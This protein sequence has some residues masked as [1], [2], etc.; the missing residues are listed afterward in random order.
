[1]SEKSPLARLSE[2]GQCVWIDQLSSR[3]LRSGELGE[4]IA[5]DSVVGVTTNPTIF[6]NAIGEEVERE[7]LE[8]LSADDGTIEEIATA[9]MAADV[10][11]A[12]DL[13]RPLW[14]GGEGRRGWVSIEIDPRFAHDAAATFAQGE[15]LNRLIDRPN[16]YV[17]VPATD[18]GVV[19]I[20]E[21]IARGRSVN[22]T[23]LFSESRH[24]QVALAYMNGLRRLIVDGGDPARVA[25]VASFFVS[26]VDVEADR[27]LREVGAPTDLLGSLAVANARLAYRSF[28]EI[29]GEEEFEPLADAGASPQWCLW[30]STSTKD[31]DDRDVRYVEELIGPD[32]ITTL[33]PDT[34][35]AFQDH[36]VAE[37]TLGARAPE[38]RRTVERIE[39]LGID[40]AD[41]AAVL[42][43]DGV[44]AFVASY[45]NLLA[46]L[47]EAVDE[48]GGPVA[49]RARA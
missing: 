36:G 15:S 48:V 4:L 40:V 44:A 38:A 43:R 7:R 22:V 47:G 1:M 2:I 8:G 24:R 3:M 39:A 30:A 33:P 49:G 6:A 19:A 32:T 25:S 31:P 9:Y 42:E 13:L 29:F 21:L 20:E 17:K 28:Q 34:L 26:R 35:R 41:V 16:L 14:D 11:A 45:E 37:E 46:D 27:R 23:L 12:C 18:A 5:D 10:I